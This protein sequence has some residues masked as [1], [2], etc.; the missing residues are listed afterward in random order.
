MSSEYSVASAKAS[1]MT[2]DDNNKKWV[3]SGSSSG[4]SKVHIYQHTVNNTFRVVGWKIQDHEVV[5]NCSILKGLKYFQA[6]PTFHQWR[7]N[8]QVY[9]LNFTNKDE[10]EAFAAAMLRA[11]SIL[12]QAITQNHRTSNQVQ[13][14]YQTIG[15]SGVS[16]ND[17]AEYREWMN[18]E[19]GD[20]KSST[21]DGVQYSS[22]SANHVS[23]PTTPGATPAPSTSG[24][25][26]TSSAPPMSLLPSGPQHISA[27]LSPAPAPP[28]P[29]PPPPASNLSG[30]VTLPRQQPKSN[31]APISLASAL[32]SA[33]LKKTPQKQNNEATTSD[34]RPS[35]AM[36]GLASM[37]DEMT[38]TL[39]RRRAQAENSTD[40][41]SSSA[42]R[43]N[44]SNSVSPNK[45][46][47]IESPQF[48]HRAHL[49]SSGEDVKSQAMDT[50]DMEKMKQEILCEIKKEL[51]KMK[52]DIIDAIR[53]ELNRR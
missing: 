27:P 3:H 13:P 50:F 12:G 42:G 21:Q 47:G 43:P 19:N 4:L 49:D 51:N 17:Y 37:M 53:V 2:Y 38:R 52:Q 30:L 11:L 10:A 26:R 44:S 32:A 39:A 33:K 16:L 31:P 22:S 8:K 35:H 7:D 46:S 34:S 36:G 18:N 9:G 14:L 20:K 29:P 23:H 25:H 40:Q 45:A 48:S 24:H 41:E 15:H 1:V 28:P 5:I 6:T